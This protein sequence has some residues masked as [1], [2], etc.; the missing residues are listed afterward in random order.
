MFHLKLT[1]SYNNKFMFSFYLG[2]I[3]YR[4]A[5]QH[6]LKKSKT[7]SKK[8]IHPSFLTSRCSIVLFYTAL[9]V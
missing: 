6:T 9:S 2:G 4:T 5:L 1:H 7:F 3:P 8:I